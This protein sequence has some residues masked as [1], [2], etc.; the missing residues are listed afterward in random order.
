MRTMSAS[1]SRRRRSRRC[2]CRRKRRSRRWVR[3]SR[4]CLRTARGAGTRTG[5]CGWPRRQKCPGKKTATRARRCDA[6]G[7]APASAAAMAPRP[8]RLASARPSTIDTATPTPPRGALSARGL[9]RR[10]PAAA[11]C[12]RAHVRFAHNR[13]KIAGACCT[14]PALTRAWPRGWRPR[15]RQPGASRARQEEMRVRDAHARVS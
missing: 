13:K 1:P 10:A 4:A 3:A 6:A 9:P 7:I 8:A 11:Q 5:R 14:C 2:Y 12:A 15:A